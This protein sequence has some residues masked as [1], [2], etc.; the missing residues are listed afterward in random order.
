MIAIFPEA[1]SFA[2]RGMVE[3]IAVSTRK[4]YEKKTTPKLDLFE[5]VK[6]MGICLESMRYQAMAALIAKDCR[7]RFDVSIVLSDDLSR[8]ERSTPQLQFLL[9]HMVGH[10]L[11]HLQPKI[12][13]GELEATGYRE[14][15]CPLS[16]YASGGQDPSG[17]RPVSENSLELK[18]ELDCD[19]FAAAL[20]MPK[21]MILHAWQ[22][23]SDLDKI[24]ILF[25]VTRACLERR[26]EDL[27]AMT[28]RPHN[29][30][31]AE[32]ALKGKQ[33]GNIET[34]VVTKPQESYPDPPKSSPVPPT[35]QPKAAPQV[36]T[37]TPRGMARIREIAKMLDKSQ[38]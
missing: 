32:S 25:G 13:R 14:L 26:L 9:A 5:L 19:Q 12:A 35:P 36:S 1:L 3:H 30:F 38:S 17:G 22:R 15:V 24:A 37:G 34:L 11:I 7:G 16:R 29:F 8:T 20:L 33:K 2:E 27:G 21:G 18:R 4:T 28:R 23:V 31:E 6:S 10:F